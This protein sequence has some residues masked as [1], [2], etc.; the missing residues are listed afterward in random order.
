MDS[1]LERMNCKLSEVNEDRRGFLRK[2]KT[3]L[4][5]IAIYIGISELSSAQ[6]SS[7]EANKKK[8]ISQTTGLVSSVQQVDI[9]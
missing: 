1:K 9:G 4:G 5:G 8:R 7:S 6:E 2:L 3:T